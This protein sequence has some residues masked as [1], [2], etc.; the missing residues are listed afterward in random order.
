MRLDEV[1]CEDSVA[2]VTGGIF[3]IRFTIH[4]KRPAPLNEQSGTSQKQSGN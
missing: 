4:A 1:N 2:E 3:A